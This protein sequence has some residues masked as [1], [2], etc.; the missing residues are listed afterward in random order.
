[1]KK[2]SR[3]KII[4]RSL[5]LL[6]VVYIAAALVPY[7]FV[8]APPEAAAASVLAAMPAAANVQSGTA[9]RATLVTTGEEA[10][11][12]RLNLIANAKESLIVGTYL[13]GNDDSGRAIASA[14]RAAADRGVRVRILTDGLVG[15]GNLFASSLGYALGAYPGI[16]LRFYNP[17]NPLAPWG[18]N[19]RFHEKYVIADESLFVLGGR[20]ISN[21][22]LTPMS[23]PAYNYDLDVLICGSKAE[24]ASAVTQLVQYFDHLW[25]TQCAPQ[26]QTIP[27]Y[28]SASTEALAKELDSLYAAL[29]QQHAQAMQPTDWAQKTIPIQGAVLLTNPINPCV[30]EPTVWA[31]LMALS[32]NAKERVWVQN[33]YLVLN[34]QMKNDLSKLAALP[35]ELIVL[36]NSKASGNNI[37][38]SSDALIHKGA[39]QK[40]DLSLYEFQGDRSMHTKTMLIDQDLSI[41]GSFNFDIRSAYLSTEL[42]LVVKSEEVNQMLEDY[43]LEMRANSLLTNA[44]PEASDTL[45]LVTPKETPWSKDLILHI[46]APFVAL[47]RFL[48]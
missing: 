27:F 34:G 32:S 12:V 24:K 19:A 39:I 29:C 38:A 11:D 36:T 25:L 17:I 15:G 37:V 31:E 2:R 42:M 47:F 16:E 43:M 26:Y 33:P 46:A 20:N 8:P 30:K 21:E 14:L 35:T 7:L 48:I 9:D 3:G 41:F 22:F 4:R 6:L 40:M 44:S 45:P 28:A 10:L 18:L 13:Y 5:C 1:M 23:H